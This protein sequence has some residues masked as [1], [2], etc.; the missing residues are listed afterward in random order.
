MSK[1]NKT[2]KC[3]IVMPISKCDGCTPEHWKE[4]YNILCE[5]I[6]DCGFEPNLVSNSK[7]VGVIQ[8]R[9][10]QNLYNNPIVV[11]DVSGKNPNVMF[12]LGLRLAFDKPTIII[13][14]DKTD[15]TFDT[16]PIEHLEYPRDLRFT[17]IKKFKDNLSKKI[18]H[19][20]KESQENSNYTTFLKHFGEYKIQNLDQTKISSDQYIIDSLDS[21]KERIESLKSNHD[22]NSLL[23]Y[24]DERE[25]DSRIIDSAVGE[26][27]KI[28][29]FTD[30][31][32][33]KPAGYKKD[34]IEF[35]LN[36]EEVK[37]TNN[38][39]KDITEMVEFM[40]EDLPF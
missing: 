26:F 34:L 19:T 30:I 33:V 40:T 9:I 36:S 5:S 17:K 4:V 10:I 39:R 3:G 31:Y 25:I 29:G 13:K 14:D 2:E 8:K 37:L 27:C 38:T 32:D 6:Y 7:D 1:E 21:I 20:Y 23:K 11:C 35:L 16:S 28:H 18:E 12:E 15:Y 22:N 24:F